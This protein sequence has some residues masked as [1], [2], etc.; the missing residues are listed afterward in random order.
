MRQRRLRS[1]GLLA[2]AVVAITCTDA[3]TSPT[4]TN[5]TGAGTARI[6]MSP[7]FSPEAA[8]IYSGLAAFGLEVT[9]VHVL[10]TGP[11]GS[12]KDTVIAF[13]VGQDQLTIE[14]PVPSSGTDQA[15]DALIEL[16][17]DQHVVLFSGHQTVIARAGGLQPENP[18]VIVISYTGPGKST[19]TVT[20]SP[21]DTTIAGTASVGI[22][23]TAVDS[24]GLP[25][26]NLLVQFVV[27][28][29]T[30][31]VA[32]STGDATGT[33]TGL[34]KRGVTTVSAVTPL[35]V[36]GSSRIT[37]VPA[38]ARVVVISG[39]GQTGV[40]GRPLALP[41]VV[42]V[43]ATDNLPV[44]GASVTFRAV[45][46]GGSVQQAT[47][48]AD[49]NGRASTTLTLGPISGA[50]AY[51]AGSGALTPVNVSATATPAPAAAIAIVSGDA[52]TDTVGKTLAQPLV[53]KVTDQFGVAVGG[54]TVTWTRIAGNGEIGRAHV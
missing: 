9:E 40:A 51:E 19:K 50:Y 37:F 36:A 32:T 6:R 28:D 22:R 7:S 42:E 54:A 48:I 23:A 31:A 41:L 1:V 39:N 34:G 44:P 46:A 33:L 53:V 8:R 52:Q 29:A 49:A 3:P 21:P 15:F 17:N 38:T 5:P 24:A 20:F 35:G 11:D 10:L 4:K 18:P 2:L 27:T 45:T 14:I 12:K 13:P 26:P 30:L 25:V 47:V 43:Q 16:R